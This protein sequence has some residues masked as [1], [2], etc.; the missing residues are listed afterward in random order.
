MQ[1]PLHIISWISEWIL[2]NVLPEIMTKLIV[3]LQRSDIPEE[4]FGAKPKTTY[5][6]GKNYCRTEEQPGSRAEH[7]CRVDHQRTKCLVP[8]PSTGRS[9]AGG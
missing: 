9:N 2:T 5:W 3:R 8:K 1:L 4:N 7:S 6:A